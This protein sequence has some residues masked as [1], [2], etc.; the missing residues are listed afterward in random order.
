MMD[1]LQLFLSRRV[2]IVTALTLPIMASNLSASTASETGWAALREGGIVLFRHANAPGT[3]DPPGFR[4]DDCTTQRN[5]DAAGRAQA[6]RIGEAFATAGIT[7]TA[8]LASR[9]CRARDT[10][11]LAFPGRVKAEPAFDSFFD[12][13]RLGPER[14]AAARHVMDRWQGPGALVVV[15]HQVNITA[16]TGIVPASGE[17][18]ALTRQDGGWRVAGRIRP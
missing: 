16:L 4:L 12:E 17:G 14:T 7:V 8:V 6:R 9:W 3:G 1:M 11:E 15:T 13:R 2:A 10:A 18:V 5:L